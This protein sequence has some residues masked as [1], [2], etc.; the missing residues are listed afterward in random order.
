MSET[1]L[2]LSQLRDVREP[3]APEGAPLILIAANLVALGAL[4][5]LIYW[6]HRQRRERWRVQAIQQIKTAYSLDPQESVLTLAKTL[7]QIMLDRCAAS[8]SGVGK[9]WLQE[10]DKEFA[11][12]WFTQGEGQVFGAAL[13]KKGS[14]PTDTLPLCKQV[15]KLIRALPTRP[16]PNR[17]TAA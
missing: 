14:I 13:Y 9:I 8:A 1:E 4:M 17:A 12:H 6:K 11:T 5:G 2:L 15:E 3:L 7:R 16:S 10:L